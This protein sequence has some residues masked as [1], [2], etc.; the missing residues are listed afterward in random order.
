MNSDEQEIKKIE[1]ARSLFHEQMHL[2]REKNRQLFSL[3]R[4]R[5]E[6]EKLVE[7]KARLARMNQSNDSLPPNHNF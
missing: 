3:F 5:L 2:L 4:T 6:Q 7:I 1:S